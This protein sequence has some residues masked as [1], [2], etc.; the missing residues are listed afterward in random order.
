VRSVDPLSTTI[1]S[2]T[3]EA[4]AART[5]VPIATSSLRAGMM[6][7][8]GECRPR[9]SD[10]RSSGSDRRDMRTRPGGHVRGGNQPKG[11][12]LGVGLLRPLLRLLAHGPADQLTEAVLEGP[13]RLPAEAC[14]RPGRVH[15]AV[16][17]V[18]RSEFA[19][20]HDL[21]GATEL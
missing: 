4:G 15:D 7:T 21:D 20:G 12:Q 6:S 18:A 3:R 9:W 19:A 11:P 1:T 14:P 10:A 5:T 16:S 8:T 13:L 2:S 17:D